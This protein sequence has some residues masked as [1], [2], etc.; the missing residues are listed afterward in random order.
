MQ[1]RECG[2]EQHARRI[3]WLA[4]CHLPRAVVELRVAD[5]QLHGLAYQPARPQAAA[6]IVAQCGQ[7]HAA[8]VLAEQ[9]VCEGHAV[10]YALDLAL[11]VKRAHRFIVLAP[12]VAQQRVTLFAEYAVHKGRVACSQIADRMHAQTVQPRGGTPADIKQRVCGK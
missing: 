11:G 8:F 2:L 10:A 7:A 3:G 5:G 1:Q 12:R 6:Y 4:E 9:V